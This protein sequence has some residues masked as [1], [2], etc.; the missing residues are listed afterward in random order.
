MK[1]RLGAAVLAAA[2][3]PLTAVTTSSPASAGVDTTPPEVGSCHDLTMA[4]GYDESDPDPAVDCAGPHTSITVAVVELEQAPDWTD[5]SSYPDSVW[6]TCGNAFELALG[7]NPKLIRRSAHTWFWFMPTRVQREAGALWVRC[8]LTLLGGDRLLKLPQELVL[9]GLPLPN[10]VAKCRQ[11]KRAD[12]AYTAC[13]QPHQFRATL[14]IRYPHSSYPG[15]RAAKRFALR[16]CR[17]RATSVFFYEYV[18]TR[19]AWRNGYRHAVCL[20]K[21]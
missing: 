4:E 14:S 7:D 3:I 11:G 12:Y 10:A 16:K 2:L 21:D 6:R 9:G 5:P 20:Y 18:G 19:A 8:D 15:P 1:L 13:S 17:A